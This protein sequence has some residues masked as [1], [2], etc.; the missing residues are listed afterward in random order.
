MHE[1]PENEKWDQP[2]IFQAHLCTVSFVMHISKTWGFLVSS[3]LP[4]QVSVPCMFK[5]MEVEGLLLGKFLC[6]GE[7]SADLYLGIE[8]RAKV[9]CRW[10]ERARQS[11][12]RI[13]ALFP[14]SSTGVLRRAPL[15][16]QTSG[17]SS[18]CSNA[19]PVFIQPTD[20]DVGCFLSLRLQSSGALSPLNDEA[21]DT[22]C[23]S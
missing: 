16:I 4:W 22:T 6:V 21:A 15:P 3:L 9:R 17:W 2:I 8:G 7:T 5:V 18:H 20:T 14:S 23:M 10:D 13:S 1:I 19:V 11:K 12:V